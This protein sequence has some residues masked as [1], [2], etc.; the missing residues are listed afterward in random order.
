[1]LGRELL[2]N[3]SLA[4]RNVVV[5]FPQHLFLIDLELA[6]LGL[7]LSFEHEF[8]L[9]VATTYS[10]ALS[11]QLSKADLTHGASKALQVYRDAHVHLAV[12]ICTGFI[13]LRCYLIQIALI[14]DLLKARERK[15][16]VLVNARCRW[17]FPGSKGLKLS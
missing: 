11:G 7:L 9:A 6:L 10:H 2:V 17:L 4:V 1:M 14:L 5:R 8:G 12:E 13:P 15:Y 3:R 16:F